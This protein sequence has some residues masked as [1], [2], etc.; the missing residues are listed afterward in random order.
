MNRMRVI[1]LAILAI[2]VLAATGA[3]RAATPRLP[4]ATLPHPA[5]RS[6]PA[7]VILI[8]PS[9][10][11]AAATRAPAP[12]TRYIHRDGLA[13]PVPPADRAP[14][15]DPAAVDPAGLVDALAPPMPESDGPDPALDPSALDTAPAALDLWIP[16]PVRLIVRPA[17]PPM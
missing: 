16:G 3:K 6:E 17:W 5:I 4:M 2:A 14:D 8:I 10:V 7:A 1:T 9:P 13:Y 11:P 12:A 15:L